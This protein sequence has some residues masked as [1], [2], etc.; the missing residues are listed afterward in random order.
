MKSIRH[1]VFEC[2]EEDIQTNKG[3]LETESF[4]Y[5]LK[6]QQQNIL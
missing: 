4:I 3:E 1:L 6:N 5:I 2:L